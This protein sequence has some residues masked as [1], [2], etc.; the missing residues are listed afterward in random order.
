MFRTVTL[1]LAVLAIGG[2]RMDALRSMVEEL[3]R[4]A[5]EPGRTLGLFYLLIGRRVHKADGTLVCKGMT[6]R[7]LAAL[8]K[9]ARWPKEAARDL[10]LDP[11]K[12]PP[13]DRL[14]FWYAAISSARVDSPEARVAGEA[15]AKVLEPLGYRVT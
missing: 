3:K 1:Q 9:K 13:R 10:G 6:W 4:R 14:Q 15:L 12:L 2:L 11:S 7:E 8:L 5:L